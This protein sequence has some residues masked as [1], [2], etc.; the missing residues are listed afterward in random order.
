[1]KI[2]EVIKNKQVE[3]GISTAELS[4][5]TGIEY[6]ALRVALTGKRGISGSELLSLSRE[7]DLTMADFSASGEVA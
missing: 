5:R 7:L 2:F 1:M 3:R 4:R 6:E